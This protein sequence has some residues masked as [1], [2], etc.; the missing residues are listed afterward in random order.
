MKHVNAN[1]DHVKVV[2]RHVEHMEEITEKMFL[3][4]GEATEKE[5]LM[6][7]YLHLS[8]AVE[9]LF[10]RI[11]QLSIG[12]DQLGL[13]KRVTT[14]LVKAHDM[15]K[16]VFDLQSELHG[17][18]ELLMI[19]LG[20]DVWKCPTSYVISSELEFAVMVHIPVAQRTSY[21]LSLIHI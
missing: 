16:Q 20:S 19:N 21:M 11:K 3:S 18:T 1:M 2:S 17:S 15:Q 10:D 8:I 13:H 12:L 4:L 14:H 9:V 5:M 7:L 6:E